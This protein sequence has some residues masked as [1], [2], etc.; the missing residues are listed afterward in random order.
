MRDDVFVRDGVA[1]EHSQ[2]EAPARVVDYLARVEDNG[3]F[4]GLM[5]R[6][7]LQRA[8]ALPNVLGNDWLHVAR[9]AF[10]GRVHTVATVHVNRELG[11]TSVDVRS[12][13]TTFGAARWQARA[14]QLVIAWQ[15]FRDIAWDH[16]AVRIARPP[17][18]AWPLGVRAALASIRWP[19][20]AWHIVTPLVASVAER[21]RGRPIWNLYLRLARGAGKKP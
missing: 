10:Q 15:V 2:L 19:D 18:G 6:P 17:G 1:H 13:L 3:V 16:R 4:Y 14:P 9:I 20:L 7:V 11:G 12:I 8:G 5:P 21:P